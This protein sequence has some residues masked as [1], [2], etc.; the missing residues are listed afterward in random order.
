MA[1]KVIND[2]K[3]CLNDK[4]SF[5]LEAG[6]GAGKT[7]TLIKTIEYLQNQE[8]SNYKILCITYTNIAKD[9]VLNRLKKNLA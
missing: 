3:K 6:A 7:Y 5:L 8:T 4:K 1:R 9:E 2:I